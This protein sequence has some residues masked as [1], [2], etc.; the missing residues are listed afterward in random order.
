MSTIGQDV[1]YEMELAMII[2][3]HNSL[4]TQKQVLLLESVT[5]N[6]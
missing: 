5:G 2:H 1:C 3:I 6:M 4:A